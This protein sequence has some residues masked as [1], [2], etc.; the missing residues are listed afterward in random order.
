MINKSIIQDIDKKIK[1][2]ELERNTLFISISNKITRS[3]VWEKTITNSK[4][5]GK[6]IQKYLEAKITNN[7]DDY[8]I[9]I[10]IITES[11]KISTDELTHKLKKNISK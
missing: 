7:L 8:F 4:N 5:I 6:E 11:K 2:K 9:K 1:N 3:V 10:D